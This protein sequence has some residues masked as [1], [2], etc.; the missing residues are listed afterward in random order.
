MNDG[1][2]SYSH[3]AGSVSAE[4]TVGGLA[5]VNDG[6]I[7]NSYVTGSVSGEGAGFEGWSITAEGELRVISV[8]GSG[9][10]VVGGLVGWNG[11]TISTSY[12]TGDVSTAI[13]VGGLVGINLDG[14]TVIASYA[15]GRVRDHGVVSYPSGV[16]P[17]NQVGGLVGLNVGSIIA[18]FWDMRT[19]GQQ[20]GVGQ[21]ESTGAEAKTTA[22]LQSPTGYTGPYVAWNIDLDN[23][24]RDFDDTTGIDDFW[25]FGTSNQYPVL[26]ADFDGDSNT[27]WWEF[28]RQIGNRPTPTPTPSPTPIPTPTP[29][30]MPTPTPTPTPTPPPT[31]T[32]TPSPTPTP[33]PTDTP[34]PIPTATT[35]R[36]PEPTPTLAVPDSA[37]ASA[38]TSAHPA[39]ANTPVEAS[40]TRAIPGPTPVA[41]SGGF[42]CNSTVPL[43]KSTAMVNLLLMTGPLPMAAFLK[44]RTRRVGRE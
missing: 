27:I 34:T 44:R 37:P 39:P 7:S 22:Q 38:D 10:S 16:H 30:P 6:A 29:T 20:L 23:A 40:P 18:S 15:T 42:G 8:A 9:G 43:S 25:D 26:K 36:T 12:A 21:G 35:S 11:G 5:G 28:G 31:L 3:A 17:G 1:E 14:A 13:A 24:D 2:I 32:H 19:S 4:G 33:V 41:D